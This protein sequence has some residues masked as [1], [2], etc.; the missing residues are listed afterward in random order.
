MNEGE[1]E[2]ESEREREIPEKITQNNSQG[3]FF[4]IISCGSVSVLGGPVR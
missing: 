3:V 2:N 1:S 4:V